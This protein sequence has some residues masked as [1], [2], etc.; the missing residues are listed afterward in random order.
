M[1]RFIEDLDRDTLTQLAQRAAHDGEHAI[2]QSIQ[3]ALTRDG[4]E[5]RE[6]MRVARRYMR[7]LAR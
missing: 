4:E 5:R 7:Q 1:T 3:D 6:G 2:L